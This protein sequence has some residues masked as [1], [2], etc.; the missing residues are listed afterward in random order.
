[1]GS[2]SLG[3]LRGK[4][5]CGQGSVLHHCGPATVR[6]AVFLEDL[7]GNYVV[8]C[9]LE[10]GLIEDSSGGWGCPK[11]WPSFGRDV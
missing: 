10:F 8:Q 4:T 3:V 6:R 5:Y 11:T 2:W 7:H 9:L 1:M